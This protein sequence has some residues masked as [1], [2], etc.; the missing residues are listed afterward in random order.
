MGTLTSIVAIG[1]LNRA[2]GATMAATTADG[3]YPVA[4]LANARLSSPYRST[5]GSLTGQSIDVDLGATY[6]DLDVMALLGCNFQDAATRSPV[7]ST[8]SDYSSP[9]YNPGSGNAF[10]VSTYPAL[11]ADVPT[12]GRNMIV[13][14]GSSKSARYARFTCADSGN[15][16]NYLSARVYWVG[17]VWQPVIGIDM[18]DGG[19]ER[20]LEYVGEPGM[21]RRLEI[22]RYSHAFLTEGEAR[23]FRSIART[24]LRTGRLLVVARPLSPSVWLNGEALHC[25]MR[26]VSK[27]TPVFANGSY[28][29]K[30]TLEFIEVED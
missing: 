9:V 11:V 30:V 13:F 25:S 18:G 29:W 6:T 10:D 7:L 2:S 26:S 8:H 1:Y 19:L 24:K 3:S 20:D 14:P 21:E 12:Y 16:S 22:M 5:A 4:N 17:P 15:P 28:H 23:Q 27:E